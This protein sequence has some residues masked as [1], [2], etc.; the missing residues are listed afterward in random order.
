[1]NYCSSG[2]L[3]CLIAV[4]YPDG[5]EKLVRHRSLA[6]SEY[7]PVIDTKGEGFSCNIE[8]CAAAALKRHVLDILYG[9]DI[10]EAVEYSIE[11]SG[12]Q[13]GE[14]QDVLALSQKISQQFFVY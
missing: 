6:I 3:Y 13:F 14:G 5:F 1:M 7:D 10:V 12:F 2:R 4:H 9:S 8:V 11:A